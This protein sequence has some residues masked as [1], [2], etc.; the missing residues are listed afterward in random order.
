MYVRP[1]CLFVTFSYNILFYINVF[2]FLG[3]S[4][5]FWNIYLKDDGL[6]ENHER[7]EVVLKAQKNA[8]LGAR[9]RASVEIVDP[10]HGKVSACSLLDQNGLENVFHLLFVRS[11]KNITDIY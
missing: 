5:K 3:V 2:S 6:E 8:V 9:S 7:L 10:R 4:V 11:V 1:V